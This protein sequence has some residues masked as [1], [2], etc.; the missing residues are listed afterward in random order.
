[1]PIDDEVQA[2]ELTEKLKA[3]LPLRVR[4]TRQMIKGLKD[5]GKAFDP[6][7]EYTVDSVFYS[8]DAGGIICAIKGDLEGEEIFAVSITHL[9]VAELWYELAP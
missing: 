2:R 1:M 4:P 3:S 5:Q 8:G 6:N 7:C 9:G